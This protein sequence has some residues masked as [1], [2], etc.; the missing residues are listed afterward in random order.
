MSLC[1]GMK[2]KLKSRF[3]V[4][5]DD[6]VLPPPPVRARGK[7]KPDDQQADLGPKRNRGGR[8]TP[9]STGYIPVA[10]SGHLGSNLTSVPG[11]TSISTNFNPATGANSLPQAISTNFT[12]QLVPIACLVLPV[13]CQGSLACLPQFLRS[14][15]LRVCRIS[16]V[17][18]GRQLPLMIP[19]SNKVTMFF[20]HL[21]NLIFSCSLFNYF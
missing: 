10:N 6:R 8:A 2:G 9:V 15:V 14:L 7:R 16:P 1:T 11:V 5:S 21:F 12:P 3:V 19:L 13:S 17:K 20:Y 4:L 18:I